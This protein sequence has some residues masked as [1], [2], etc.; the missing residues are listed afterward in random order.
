M[1]PSPLPATPLARERLPTGLFTEAGRAGFPG[2]T[3]LLVFSENGPRSKTTAPAGGP[4]AS[5]RALLPAPFCELF[6]LHTVSVL[7]KWGCAFQ[8]ASGDNASCL[9]RGQPTDTI[10][11]KNSFVFQP[12]ARAWGGCA[13]SLRA[14][15]GGAARL[16]ATLCPA[17]N[18]GGW[19]AHAARGGRRSGAPGG[20]HWD[21]SKASPLLGMPPTWPVAAEVGADSQGL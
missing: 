13:D 5:R 10:I 6:N 7:S 19:G 2:A 20:A 3:S 8:D 12:R 1:S 14:G 21:P 9:D 15:W 18:L 4:R 16:P 17:L 11:N